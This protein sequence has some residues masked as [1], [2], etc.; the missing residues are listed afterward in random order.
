MRTLV[1]KSSGSK[2]FSHF[3]SDIT[4]FGGCRLCIVFAIGCVDD[5]TG[6]IDDKS[7]FIVETVFAYVFKASAL[8]ADAGYKEKMPRYYFTYR[9]KGFGACST[10]HIHHV[11]RIAPSQ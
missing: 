4:G 10:Y 3:A 5:G 6:A 2:N 7:T 8:C 9:L 11:Y 1:Y